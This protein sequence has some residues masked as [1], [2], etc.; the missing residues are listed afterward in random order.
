MRV[1]VIDDI[2]QIRKIICRMLKDHDVVECRSG[3]EALDVLKNDEAFDVIL[4]DMDMGVMDGATFY[5]TLAER[6]PALSDRVIFVTGGGSNAEQNRFLAV[7]D[8]PIVS[9]PFGV[10]D[11]NHAISSVGME[12][13]HG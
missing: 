13:S 7:T 9:K 2:P 1:L 12:M 6:N 4:S 3:E 11:L 10:K 8:R 5:A